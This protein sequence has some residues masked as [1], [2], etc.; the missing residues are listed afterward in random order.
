MEVNQLCKS[1]GTLEG[2]HPHRAIYRFLAARIDLMRSFPC[3]SVCPFSVD[4]C[5]D[6]EELKHTVGD[7]MAISGNVRPTTA[8][9]AE[10]STMW[11]SR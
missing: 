4:N 10:P 5:G 8:L 11:S 9:R 6:L 2:R 1:F 7:K 3:V